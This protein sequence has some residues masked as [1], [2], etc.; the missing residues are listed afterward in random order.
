MNILDVKNIILGV[1]E[2]LVKRGV[3][4]DE[5]GLGVYYVLTTL[6]LVSPEAAQAMP[7]LYDSVA[8]LN[9]T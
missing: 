5:R 2:K 3:T 1:L 7:W 4:Q 6:T 9:D 8:P